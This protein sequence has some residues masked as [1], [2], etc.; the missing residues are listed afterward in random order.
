[1]EKKSPHFVYAKLSELISE[2]EFD[3]GQVQ[4]WAERAEASYNDDMSGIIGGAGS[5]A[6]SIQKMR[7]HLDKF[8]DREND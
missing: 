8:Y 1:M 3:V 6:A 5:A 2:L 4:W 7:N